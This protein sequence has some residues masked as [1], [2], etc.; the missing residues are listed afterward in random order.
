MEV[1]LQGKGLFFLLLIA[2]SNS[3]PHDRLV[4]LVRDAEHLVDV[5]QII[6]AI[7]NLL[8]SLFANWSTLSNLSPDEAGPPQDHFQ[9][10]Q[11]HLK[12]IN[13]LKTKL[14]KRT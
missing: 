9:P 3:S 12:R 10:K 5:E 4:L 6:L 11:E 1:A 2:G 7:F 14:Q 13:E 8:C